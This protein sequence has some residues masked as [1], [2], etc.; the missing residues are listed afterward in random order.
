MHRRR[1][2]RLGRQLST[3]VLSA[4]QLS[5]S[6]RQ[7]ATM[8]AARRALGLAR[9]VSARE[10]SSFSLPRFTFSPCVPL[11]THHRVAMFK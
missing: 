8:L 11:L 1:R 3:R 7:T 5:P 9:Q 4:S 10:A 2:T 6:S